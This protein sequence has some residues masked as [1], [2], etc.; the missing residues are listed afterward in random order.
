[1]TVFSCGRKF[2]EAVTDNKNVFQE[3]E[4]IRVEVIYRRRLYRNWYAVEAWLGD[5]YELVS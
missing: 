2:E 4:I 5:I 1:L 3:E